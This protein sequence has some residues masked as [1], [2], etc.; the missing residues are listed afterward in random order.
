MMCGESK[1]FNRNNGGKIWRRKA[2][3][4]SSQKNPSRAATLPALPV[5]TKDHFRM[6]PV[7]I[8]DYSWD[9]EGFFNDA[10]LEPRR[11]ITLG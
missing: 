1:A 11:P 4:S 6:G 9:K 7:G 8:A 5:D 3:I 2:W 10:L